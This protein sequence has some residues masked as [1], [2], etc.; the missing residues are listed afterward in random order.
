MRRVRESGSKAS[1]AISQMDLGFLNSKTMGLE[2]VFNLRYH[3]R[4]HLKISREAFVI[5]T[6]GGCY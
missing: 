5:V 2:E 3:P 1:S 6:T 4:G